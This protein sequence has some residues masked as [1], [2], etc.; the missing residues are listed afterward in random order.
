MGS[1]DIRKISMF[2]SAWTPFPVEPRAGILSKGVEVEPL[3]ERRM[4]GNALLADPRELVRVDF[5]GDEVVELA[6]C[7]RETALELRVSCMELVRGVRLRIC[8][9]EC[10]VARGD[11]VELD[12]RELWEGFCFRH[13]RRPSLDG[14]HVVKILRRRRRT[15]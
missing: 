13:L 6:V 9:V 2:G 4:L 14:A 3:P 11:E 8:I 5:D 15:C 7:A 10:E 1:K 12:C